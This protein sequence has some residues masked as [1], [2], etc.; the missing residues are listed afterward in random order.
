MFTRV[1]WLFHKVI[2]LQIIQTPTH[3]LTRPS[4]DAF[5]PFGLISRACSVITKN[6]TH[7][8]N[9]MKNVESFHYKFLRTNHARGA[10]YHFG[11]MIPSVSKMQCTTR[12][13]YS[14][15][16]LFK[17]LTSMNIARDNHNRIIHRFIEL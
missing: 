9:N 10:C 14:K 13:L 5:R 17:T 12:R 3:K 2:V 15:Q 7:I 11:T 16:N 8:W 6:Q 1:T 4:L